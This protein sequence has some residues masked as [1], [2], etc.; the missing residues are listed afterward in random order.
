MHP[1]PLLAAGFPV[2]YLHGRHDIFALPRHA[3]AL[4]RRMGAPLCLVDAG[5]AVLRESVQEVRLLGRGGSAPGGA[6]AVLLWTRGTL[7]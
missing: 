7:C 1:T 3:V 4:A 6:L 5:H 2:R